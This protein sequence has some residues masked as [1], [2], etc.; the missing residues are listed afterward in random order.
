MVVELSSGDDG[1]EDLC[2]G[3]G[4]YAEDEFVVFVVCEKLLLLILLFLMSLL[5]C[6]AEDSAAA[7]VVAEFR[8]GG[9]TE[10]CMAR[11]LITCVLFLCSL[12]LV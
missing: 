5:L 12:R 10:V 11:K 6:V 7:V 2:G 8:C 3:A 9:S 1:V 4:A